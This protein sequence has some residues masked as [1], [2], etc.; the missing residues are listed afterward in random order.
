V[1]RLPSALLLY[2]YTR[3]PASQLDN[4]RVLADSF[5]DPDA[6]CEEFGTDKEAL[7]N[8]STWWPGCLRR[9]VTVSPGLLE[10]VVCKLVGVVRMCGTEQKSLAICPLQSQSQR[11]NTC[12]VSEF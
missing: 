11:T 3:A 8:V 5:S 2:L 7:L 12:L 10:V 4:D 6:F 1:C 9:Y